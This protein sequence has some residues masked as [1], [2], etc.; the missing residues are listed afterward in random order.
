MDDVIILKR[1]HD[2]VCVR[3]AYIVFPD[4]TC[5]ELLT[6]LT[7]YVKCH[8]G[9]FPDS[10]ELVGQIQQNEANTVSHLSSDAF[11]QQ[12]K[13]DP[14]LFGF[15]KEELCVYT[16]HEISVIKRKAFKAIRIKKKNNMLSAMDIGREMKNTDVYLNLYRKIIDKRFM[17]GP[18]KQLQEYNSLRDQAKSNTILSTKNTDTSAL[19]ND[20]DKLRR[21]ADCKVC[22]EN[23]ACILCLPCSHL[24]GCVDCIDKLHKCP[25]CRA[26]IKATVRAYR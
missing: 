9:T 13:A 17:W 16:E 10:V 12:L 11:I 15:F 18:V 2:M 4:I 5:S 21:E 25:I 3:R 22:Y 19:R 14:A 24:A 1:I 26:V 20:I 23:E 7:V 6:A 8:K